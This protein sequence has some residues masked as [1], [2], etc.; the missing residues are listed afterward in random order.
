MKTE[1][2][3]QEGETAMYE[4]LEEQNRKYNREHKNDLKIDPKKYPSLWK[5]MQDSE[6][7]EKKDPEPK[8]IPDGKPVDYYSKPAGGGPYEKKKK[9]HTGLIVTLV[10]VFFIIGA[11]IAIL[12]GAFAAVRNSH[13]EDVT[14]VPHD[15]YDID[16]E[17][18]RIIE[19]EED[20]ANIDDYDVDDYDSD[21]LNHESYAAHYDEITEAWLYSEGGDSLNYT[22]FYRNEDGSYSGYI[23]RFV[24]P[25][26]DTVWTTWLIGDSYEDG[27]YWYIRDE[28][29][30]EFVGLTVNDLNDGSIEL[31]EQYSEDE[32][33]EDG[34]ATKV[35]E[36]LDVNDDFYEFLMT[37][38]Q[39]VG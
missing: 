9:N 25:G 19:D 2:P 16:T 31:T 14:Y 8:Q 27:E 3:L 7:Y 23:N 11:G 24:N 6:M 28:D 26:E 17:F 34:E 5:Q 1:N 18:D 15:E 13:T 38:D 32:A 10:I 30:G 36:P 39:F 33:Y 35:L 29:D 4:S 21:S 20:D 37:F 12:V 22:V